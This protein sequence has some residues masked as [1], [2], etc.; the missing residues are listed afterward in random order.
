MFPRRLTQLFDDNKKSYEALVQLRNPGPE[1]SHLH[2][3]LRI[4]KDRLIA[5]G[6]QWSDRSTAAQTGDIDQS[7]DRAGISDLVASIM[8]SIRELLD[9][10]ESLQPQQE[11]A[12]IPRVLGGKKVAFS[13]NNDMGEGEWSSANIRRLE[14]ILKDLTTSIDT[15]CDLSRSKVEGVGSPDDGGSSTGWKPSNEQ[16]HS[17]TPTPALPPRRNTAKKARSPSP[18]Q[19]PGTNDLT[20]L[21]YI[22][23]SLLRQRSAQGRS[24]TS[25]PSYESIAA[26]SE[27]RAVAYFSIPA[28]RD[29]SSETSQSQIAMP[30]LLDYRQGV[31]GRE[32]GKSHPD[33][34]RFEELLL[35]LLKF[36]ASKPSVYTG[37][38]KLSGW[39][40][41]VPKSR[42]AFIYE[43]PAGEQTPNVRVEDVQPRSLLSFLQNG[44]D[45]DSNNMPSLENRLKLAHNVALSVLHL[46]EI[47]VTHR[48]V[49][50]NNFLFFIDRRTLVTQD[51]IWK[52]SIIRRPYLTG[53]HQS[54]NSTS[55]VENDMQFT[56]LYHHPALGSEGGCSYSFVHDYYSLGLIL[57]EIG[58]WMPI[59]KF[60][61]SRYSLWDFKSRLQDIY[62]KKLAAKCGEGYMNA[63]LACLTAADGLDHQDERAQASGPDQLARFKIAVVD[64]LERCCRLDK[65]TEPMMFS[66]VDESIEGKAL[67][68]PTGPAEEQTQLDNPSSLGEFDRSRESIGTILAGNQTAIIRAM[69]DSP[70]VRVWSHELPALYSK[71][72]TTT[73]F[74]KLERILRKALSRW[75]SYTIDLF[76]AGKDPDTA[77]PTVYMEC[78]ST[79][80][81][82]R[83]L[84]HLNKDLRLFE[85][86]V[87]SGQVVRSKAGKKKKK[88]GKKNTEAHKSVTGASGEDSY[89]DLN[90][91]YQDK[92]NC[93]ASIGAYLNGTHLPPVTFGGAVLVNGE[94]YGMSVHH[95]L[96]DEEEIESG[97]EDRLDLQRS[98]ASRTSD[99]KIESDSMID[100]RERF[101]GLYPV[102]VS[103]DAESEDTATTG[104]ACSEA[105]SQVLSNDP[106]P[107][108]VYPFEI[109]DDDLEFDDANE[110][111]PVN[112]FWLSP[113][114][115]TASLESDDDEEYDL[116][117][118]AGILPGYGSSLIVTQPALDDVREGFFPSA[119]DVDSEHLSSHSLGYIHASSGLRRARDADALIHEIDW[120]L[121][122]INPDRLPPC[123]GP[124]PSH[125][126]DSPSYHYSQHK[127]SVGILPS[128]ELASRSVHS[129]TRTSGL[130]ARGTI[131]PSMRLVRMPGRVSP[132]HSWQVRGSFGGGG[133]SGAWVFDDSTGAVCGHVLAYS[134][135]SGVAYIAPMDVMLADMERV[136]GQRVGLPGSLP[137]K[138][139]SGRVSEFLATPVSIGSKPDKPRLRKDS[140]IGYFPPITSV[141]SNGDFTTA[142]EAAYDEAY[143]TSSTKSKDSFVPSHLGG[144]G[145]GR[146][147]LPV[148][149]GGSAPSILSPVFPTS[150]P[151]MKIKRKEVAA[152][153]SPP[154]PGGRAQSSSST[155]KAPLVDGQLL[156]GIGLGVRA[157]SRV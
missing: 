147:R 49:S 115:D 137:L 7:L 71:Y 36:P 148:P 42:C 133:D 154:V 67:A 152:S 69:V 97:L 60:W 29:E 157:M 78:T 153:P 107:R 33:K 16:Y 12:N 77:R 62:L 31:P 4:Q 156:E 58:L 45:A 79:S 20:D 85:I 34:A 37:I 88:G 102:E 119:D 44:G 123:L 64:P 149:T 76:M 113:N 139:V 23:R 70:K 144:S 136:L 54:G 51:R 39:T 53:F 146:S 122:K 75:E 124:F 1:L 145:K 138:E 110:D 83:I 56:G 24:S 82:Q 28:S 103:E 72:W 131:L 99:M 80:K 106:L 93:G 86:K 100:L 22:D 6:I 84:R 96:E 120:A 135:R 41:D 47:N 114:F 95:M 26:G 116:G 143:A 32:R 13:S 98:M 9:E 73:M 104:Y 61:K 38:M 25:P 46:H 18:D 52:G 68:E 65:N 118:T 151:V 43:I 74:P 141:S 92:P 50:S 125:I 66:H 90:P 94:P 126:S 10:A 117:D 48:N 105:S 134:D 40:M 91:H 112:D 89:H 30:V 55:S 2:L 21:A 142:V 17:N 127:S 108:A 35:A 5:W 155:T 129:H 121:I 128:A 59:G 111:D 81:C 14:E 130:F 19:P 87:A 3:K 27:N 109:P 140:S 57:L 63:V 8:G 11:T 15:L 150:P 101:R 132:S